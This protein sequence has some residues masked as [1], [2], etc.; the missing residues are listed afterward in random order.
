MHHKNE[1]ELAAEG[2]SYHLQVKPYFVV[3]TASSKN[4]ICT[5]SIMDISRTTTKGIKGIFLSNWIKNQTK[6]YTSSK[7]C[8]WFS[9]KSAIISRFISFSALNQAFEPHI[10]PQIIIF[11]LINKNYLTNP[12][13]RTYVL[14]ARGDT[15]KSVRYKNQPVEPFFSLFKYQRDFGYDDKFKFFIHTLG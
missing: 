4:K 7:L 13:L 9:S 1:Q 8:W 10:Y 6:V 11:V 12:K 5:E 2:G 14:E 3:W 15:L